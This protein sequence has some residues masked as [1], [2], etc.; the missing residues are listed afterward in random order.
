MN[1]NELFEQMYVPAHSDVPESAESVLIL[2]GARSGRFDI[3][4]FKKTGAAAACAE[5]MENTI[6]NPDEHAPESVAFWAK[7]G[8]VKEFHG[9]DNKMDWEGYLRD[10]PTERPFD[11][12]NTFPQNLVK[13]WTSF[14]PVSAFDPANAGK[15]YPLLFVLHG[16]GNTVY[17]IDSWGFVNEA[18]KREWIVIVPSLECDVVIEEILKEAAELYP[19]DLSRVYVA[20][21][22]YGSRNTN[23]LMASHPDWFAA[24]APCGGFMKDPHQPMYPAG[25]MQRKGPQEP[26]YACIAQDDFK[27]KAPIMTVMGDCDGHPFPMY[28]SEDLET[29]ASG[30]SWWGKM[31]RTEVPGKEEILKLK[32]AS[33]T[34]AEEI[35]GLPLETGCGRVET[36]RGTDFA[37]ASFRDDEGIVR[38]QVVCEKN[39]PHWPTPH[40]SELVLEFFSHFSRD[41]ETKKSIYTA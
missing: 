4:K 17:A 32:D 13:K 24:A 33:K 27:E 11:P 31:N 21:F 29:M 26:A 14:V 10:H 3:E 8:M 35:L 41:P 30:L 15:K 16:A 37:V 20:G 34:A 6:V 25:M 5:M 36:D 1:Y 40:L 23:W 7:K 2:M 18:A 22:S 19:V 9:E 28:D 39:V 12:E 38:M